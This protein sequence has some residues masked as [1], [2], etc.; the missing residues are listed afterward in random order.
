MSVAPDE[1]RQ[2]EHDK[3]RAEIAKLMAETTKINAELRWYPFVA[4]AG[5]VVGV[6]SAVV[7]LVVKLFVH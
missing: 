1:F 2:S 4:V 5:V 6:V 3:I 7:A